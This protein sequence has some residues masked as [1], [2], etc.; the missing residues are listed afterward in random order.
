[1]TM[2]TTVKLLKSSS[3]GRPFA[4]AVR[5]CF[6]DL[7]TQGV[8]AKED[9]YMK[10]IVEPHETDAGVIAILLLRVLVQGRRSMG[11]SR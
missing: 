3:R 11:N 8:S 2:K 5:I 7:L 4:D 10:L 6:I 1:M 9:P